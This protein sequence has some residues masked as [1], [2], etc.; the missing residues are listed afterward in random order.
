[1]EDLLKEILTDYVSFINGY[2]NLIKSHNRKEAD[3]IA[4]RTGTIG[5]YSFHYHGAGCRL[6]KLG[7]IC[8]FDFLP[9]NECPIKFSSWKLYEFFNTNSKWNKVNYSLDDIHKDLL[10]LVEEGKLVLLEL[11]GV[12]FLVF[13]IKDIDNF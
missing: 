4:I 12:K 1:M 9:E 2:K 8:E 7:V 3:F 11:F 13:Q 6:E 10:K 5:A